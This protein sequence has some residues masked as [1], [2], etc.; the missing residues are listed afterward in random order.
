MT[1]FVED[2][3]SDG[4]GSS[5]TNS[6]TGNNNKLLTKCKNFKEALEGDQSRPTPKRVHTQKKGKAR[7]FLQ[8]LTQRLAPVHAKQSSRN[9]DR[10]AVGS[11]A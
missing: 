4:S 3:S 8:L 2:A 6:P 5:Q 1:D 9:L 7:G 10:K 11:L